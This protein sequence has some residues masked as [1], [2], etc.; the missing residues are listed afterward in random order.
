MHGLNAK[1]RNRRLLERWAKSLVDM[2]AL[3][4]KGDSFCFSDDYKRGDIEALWQQ[5][6]SLELKSST[7]KGFCRFCT[8]A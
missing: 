2:K 1:E 5:L 6:E 8:H 4:A 7:A 3:N